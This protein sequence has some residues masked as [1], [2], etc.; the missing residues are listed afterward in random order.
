[1]Q[2]EVVAAGIEDVGALTGSLRDA[3]V[4]E[5][6]D[7]YGDTPESALWG[8]WIESPI[9]WAIRVDGETVGMFGVGA[10]RESHLI[11][12]PWLLGSDK[13]PLAMHRG[14]RQIKPYVNQM[15]DAY[16]ILFNWVD[17]RNKTS[18]RWL[19]WCGFDIHDPI[20]FGV[21]GKPFRFFLMIREDVCAS[22]TLD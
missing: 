20:P 12:S 16:P 4:R 13:L 11:G 18:V 19:E 14:I 17:S 1:M 3:D 7:A 10:S 15:L 21:S 6:K 22:L 5:I 8:S 2:I 9:S